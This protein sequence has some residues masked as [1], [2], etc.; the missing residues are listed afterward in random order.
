MGSKCVLDLEVGSCV[1]T[2]QLPPQKHSLSLSPSLS[3][4]AAE[5]LIHSFITCRTDHCDSILY[6]TPSKLLNKL[7]VCPEPCCSPAK[8][9]SAPVTTST[10]CSRNS[11]GSLSHNGFPTQSRTRPH[12]PLR[13]APPRQ[14]ISYS[15]VL[16]PKLPHSTT[17]DQASNLGRQSPLSSCPFP[18]EPLMD[19]WMDT[20]SAW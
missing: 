13:Q 8:P 9:T 4:S 6:G 16:I 1:F 19:G 20:P 5:T 15:P 12:P 14:L 10:L 2:V 11:T 7:P 18:L 17:Q 3:L